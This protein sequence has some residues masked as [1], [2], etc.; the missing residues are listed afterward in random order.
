MLN[1]VAKTRIDIEVK[2][3]VENHGKKTGRAET[4]LLEWER[5]WKYMKI[6]KYP[7]RFA[8]E[9]RLG[10]RCVSGECDASRGRYPSGV[11]RSYA[12][13]DRIFAGDLGT[14]DQNRMAGR[15]VLGLETSAASEECQEKGV[16]RGSEDSHRFRGQGPEGKKRHDQQDLL[17]YIAFNY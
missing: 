9:L 4:N 7:T 14:T 17:E 10:V 5:S 1:E 11:L 6:L 3:K 16:E 13:R 8:T 12:G 2:A 15:D